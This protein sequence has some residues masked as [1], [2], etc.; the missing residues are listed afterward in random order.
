MPR[1]RTR[2]ALVLKGYGLVGQA[3]PDNGSTSLQRNGEGL[4]QFER[5]PKSATGGLGFASSHVPDF[6]GD[7]EPL[8]GTA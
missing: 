7:V 4:L 5:E 6:S 1:Q 2:N 3:V 8:S